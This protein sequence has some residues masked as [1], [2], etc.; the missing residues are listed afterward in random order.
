[1][2]REAAET[3]DARRASLFRPSTMTPAGIHVGKVRRR[4]V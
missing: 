3:V 2:H 1:L 4:E